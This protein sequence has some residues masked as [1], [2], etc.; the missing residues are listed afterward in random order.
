MAPTDYWRFT[1]YGI[2]YLLEKEYDIIE[3]AAIDAANKMHPSTY[4]VYAQKKHVE[5]QLAGGTSSQC[6]ISTRV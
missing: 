3:I 5:G 1:E 2:R 6:V 4:W